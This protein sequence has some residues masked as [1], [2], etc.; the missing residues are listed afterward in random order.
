MWF[1]LTGGVLQG[2][3]A[4]RQESQDQQAIFSR[5]AGG[6]GLTKAAASATPGSAERSLDAG[7]M[8]T[9]GSPTAKAAATAAARELNG[10]EQRKVQPAT[11]VQGF[12]QL[13]HG[14]RN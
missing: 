2:P 11:K 6:S 5:S 8:Q 9:L 10:G 1:D 12:L 13:R 14:F 3:E 4:H 7:A